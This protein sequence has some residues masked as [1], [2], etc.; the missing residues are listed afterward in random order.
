MKILILLFFGISST[1]G[2]VDVNV[3]ALRSYIESTEASIPEKYRD[4]VAV[5]EM[6]QGLNDYAS[7]QQAQQVI[8]AHWKLLASEVDYIASSDTKKAIFFAAAQVLEPKE[9]ISL[10]TECIDNRDSNHIS[11]QQFTWA[12][13]PA[14]E[15]HRDM[16]TTSNPSAGL[17]NLAG[18]ARLLFSDNPS[19][20]KFFEN[21]LRAHGTQ[22]DGVESVELQTAQA[23]EKAPT[24]RE[25]GD[26]ESAAPKPPVHAEQIIEESISTN[27]WIWALGALIIVLVGIV[28]LR[29]SKG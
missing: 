29:K 23:G 4:P 21:Y 7:F 14:D 11:E 2:A 28:F 5:V 27:W 24:E 10:I 25:Q 8:K 9:Y 22:G 15:K 13:F 6:R 12:L 18:K 17:L 3:D 1:F 16:W 20:A 26:V 19:R